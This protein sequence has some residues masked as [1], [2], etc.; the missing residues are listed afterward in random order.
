MHFARINIELEFITVSNWE[1]GT[2]FATAR[3]LCL[4]FALDYLLKLL[5]SISSSTLLRARARTGLG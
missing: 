3:A 4:R 1:H 2:N 5:T